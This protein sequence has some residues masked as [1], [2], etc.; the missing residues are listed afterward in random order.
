[1]FIILSSC[2]TFIRQ[3]GKFNDVAF[4]KAF[5]NVDAAKVDKAAEFTGSSRDFALMLLLR[6]AGN[7]L[8]NAGTFDAPAFNK[9]LEAMKPSDF[10]G[11]TNQRVALFRKLMTTGS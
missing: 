8:D 9:H 10:T 3:P 2:G 5:N 6:L 11:D 1:M 4:N 7:R